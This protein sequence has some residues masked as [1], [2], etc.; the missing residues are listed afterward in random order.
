M[1]I[2]VKDIKGIKNNVAKC[3]NPGC[4]LEIGQDVTAGEDIGEF[5]KESERVAETESETCPH[6]K[7]ISHKTVFLFS[8]SN[9]IHER[10]KYL[11]DGIYDNET[12][13]FHGTI[14]GCGI[15]GPSQE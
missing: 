10:T 1:Y 2:G 13:M 14:K 15:V 6:N 3:R 7:R 4:E 11:L 9:A 12:R 8:D 5:L